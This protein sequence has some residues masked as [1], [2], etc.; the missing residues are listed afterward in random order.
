MKPWELEELTFS[1]RRDLL[2]ALNQHILEENERA[3]SIT[4]NNPRKERR[5]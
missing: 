4:G 3:E 2:D 5:L 1:D